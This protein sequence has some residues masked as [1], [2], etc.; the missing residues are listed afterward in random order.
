MKVNTPCAD[1]PVPAVSAHSALLAAVANSVYP[2]GEV[3][4]A[5][6]APVS[7]VVPV[8]QVA[9]VPY[10]NVTVGVVPASVK[11]KPQT[12]I[13]LPD[14]SATSCVVVAL[15][16]AMATDDL[17]V[18]AHAHGSA[19]EAE[20]DASTLS[21]PLALT[22]AFWFWLVGSDIETLPAAHACIGSARNS[23]MSRSLRIAA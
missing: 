15:P 16:I 1:G 12:K 23:A 20:P 22:A 2:P 5:F 11:V 8:P 7:V 13:V 10:S 14:E 6:I 3:T 4:P 19:H 9:P 17:A 18:P 21:A